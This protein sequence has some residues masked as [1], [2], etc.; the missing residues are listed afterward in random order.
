MASGQQIAR[1]Y[2]E[3][4]ADTSGLKRG[5]QE[6]K[7]E[8]NDVTR[9]I[10]ASSEAFTKALTGTTNVTKAYGTEFLNAMKQ[11]GA[12]SG[13]LERAARSMGVFS[14]QELYAA[15]TSVLL[16]KKVRE[17]TGAVN[18]GSM[19]AA[20]AGTA[21]RQ[22]ANEIGA[23]GSRLEQFIGGIKSSF[24]QFALI[25]GGIA[26][27]GVAAKKAFDFAKQGAVIEQT[28]ERTVLTFTQDL[29]LLGIDR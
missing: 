21:F 4:G 13:E 1:L 22:Y 29:K 2:A 15:N 27:A 18:S 5:L 11:T 23:N 12:G 7:R 3:I 17:L 28:A 14:K 16:D 8:L 9:E 24:G 6:T 25:A 20:Q 10:K 26:A 19:S